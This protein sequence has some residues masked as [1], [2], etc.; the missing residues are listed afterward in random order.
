MSSLSSSSRDD[1]SVQQC[2]CLPGQATRALHHN[3]R[4]QV[5]QRLCFWGSG[6]E[7]SPGQRTLKDC[8]TSQDALRVLPASSF[9]LSDSL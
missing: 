4:R 8:S 2:P 3:L 1:H 7:P 6:V 5:P 9:N